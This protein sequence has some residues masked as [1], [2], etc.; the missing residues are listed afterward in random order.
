[1]IVQKNSCKIRIARK[2]EAASCIKMSKT[3][4]P[5]WW[6][7]NGEL[8]KKHI[9]DC[10]EGKRCLVAISD[11]EVIAFIVWGTLWNKIHLQDIFVRE[12][13]RRSGIGKSL[14]KNAIEIGKKR[15]YKEVASDCDVSN[16]A[17][18]NLHLKSGFKK[19]GYI[20]NNWGNES[21][22]V[23]SMDIS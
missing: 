13:Y 22:Y 18:I 15:G 14:V 1:M 21:S 5:D 8:G 17:S 11:L 6:S 2:K 9:K 7:K 12:G 10:I 3:S 4:W 20:K 23:F 16:K 19:C